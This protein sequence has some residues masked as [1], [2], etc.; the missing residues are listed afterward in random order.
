MERYCV[1]NNDMIN[2]VINDM[3]F[4]DSA[5]K[6][7]NDKHVQDIARIAAK[8]A[9]SLVLSSLHLDNSIA[10]KPFSQVEEESEMAL[11]QRRVIIAHNDDG[12]PVYKHLVASSQ[13][14]MNIKIAMALVES[15]RIDDIIG[16][17]K[18][19]C[20]KQ[21]YM[22]DYAVDWLGRKRKV[23]ET[24][25]VNYRMY[26][27]LYIVPYLGDK[28]LA[29]ITTNDIQ[30]MLDEN[31]DK[32]EKLLKEIKSALRQIM[33]YAISDG[34]ISSNPCNSK[35]IE[36]PSTRKTEREAIDISDYKDIIANVYKL[37]PEDQMFICLF[38]YTGMRR[39][40][41]L[42][43][44]WEDIDFENKEIHVV[45][46]ATYPGCNNAV[47]TT[48]KTKA[49]TRMIPL[50]KSLEDKLISLR[51]SGYIFGGDAP[52]TSTGFK[53]VTKRIWKTID[54]HGA[55]LHTLRH[56]YLTY[57]VGATNDYK[58]IQGI[59]GHSDVF[60]LMNRYAHPQKSKIKE[61]TDNLHEILA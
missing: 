17:G 9:V 27:R 57:A 16:S 43:L 5:S 42:G 39:G 61:L 18:N 10:M 56:S 33:D 19:S 23:K 13:D 29:D 38:L 59:S 58:T 3:I 6:M 15:G 53:S 49:G 46:N 7:Y 60:T 26:V 52:L 51:S 31:K 32:S 8:E 1:E 37:K 44:K 14:E 54:M 45:R 24:T 11:E 40:E 35:D 2:G 41:V 12:T 30:K 22:K 50:D 48:P 4:D 36:I 21:V 34:L 55:T 25:M 20:A 47:V 28:L